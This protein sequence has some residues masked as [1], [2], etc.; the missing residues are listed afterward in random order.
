MRVVQAIELARERYHIRPD[1]VFLAGFGSGGSMALRLALNG[2]EPWAGAVSLGGPFP[3][4]C[5][6]LAQLDRVRHLPVLI[7]C[8]RDS[9]VYPPDQVC[10]DLR[11]MHVAGMHVTLRQYPCAQEL[12]PHMLADMDRWLMEQVCGTS[13]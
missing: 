8:G 7:S 10:D 1:R 4:G 11:L 3:R 13:A 9:S 2:P 12:S 5:R 6:S